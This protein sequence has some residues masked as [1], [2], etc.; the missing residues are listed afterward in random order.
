MLS[1]YLVLHH[2]IYIHIYKVDIVINS[3]YRTEAYRDEEMYLIPPA[4]FYYRAT[5]RQYGSGIK[6]E[7]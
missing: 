7:I 4:L 3:T 5:V 2:L 6:T 1:I